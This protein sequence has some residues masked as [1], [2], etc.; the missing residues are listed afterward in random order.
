MEQQRRPQ[1]Q[2]PQWLD[3]PDPN[4]DR[5][6]ALSNVNGYQGR[7]SR[8]D[9]YQS[10]ALRRWQT[11]S[12]G[13]ASDRYREAHRG[14]RQYR[15]ESDSDDDRH[16]SMRL[17]HYRED[18]HRPDPRRRYRRD[19]S[20][21]EASDSEEEDRRRRARQRERHDPRN[22]RRRSRSYDEYDEEEAED[23]RRR[24]RDRQTARDPKAPDPRPSEKYTLMKAAKSAMMAGGAEYIRCRA[25]GGEFGA[26]NGQKG[27]R[28]A[29]A[30][31]SG[32]AI[33]MMRNGRLLNSGKK[34]YAE[35]FM[36]SIYAVDFLKRVL[37]HTEFGLDAQREK[38]EWAQQAQRGGSSRRYS[39]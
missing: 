21:D 11:D 29:V 5:R 25:E 33:G 7:G 30:A 3:R 17:G 28:I 22:R 18:P 19:Y 38:A 31:V 27:K 39:R 34:P 16:R 4:D 26:W 2:P 24:G 23:D 6:S 32:S 8:S 14:L 1:A 36:T 10:E 37:R 35:A 9:P 20:D 13:S 12:E 15:N